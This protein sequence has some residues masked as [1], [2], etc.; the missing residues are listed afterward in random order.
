[1]GARQGWRSLRVLQPV[2]RRVKRFQSLYWKYFRP[3]YCEVIST[4]PGAHI[5]VISPH[6]DDD[7]IGCGGVL[8]QHVMAGAT[9][10]SVYLRDGGP[11]REA[12]A[13]EAGKLIGINEL[14]FLR[15]GAQPESEIIRRT[16]PGTRAEIEVQEDTIAGLRAVVDRV[17]PDLV[18]APF[19]LDPHPDH[20]A[21]ARLLS[22][23][24]ER[25]SCIRTCFL[26]EVWS[27]LVP[28]VL[29]DITAQAETKRRAIRAHRT[30]VETIDM[31]TGMLGLNAY[32]AEMNRVRGYAEAYLR[33]EP[34]ELRQ[35][36]QEIDWHTGAATRV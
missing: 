23:V 16:R 28:N 34:W 2:R 5:L 19:F 1:M 20:A 32:R 9:I 14:V 35:M 36:L 6:I 24:V 31:S 12:E 11:I 13:R 27:P 21:G 17:H 33:L 18:Y 4:P 22:A 7:V 26:Y 3:L 29:V 8:R 10:T 25:R 15:W 30:Q